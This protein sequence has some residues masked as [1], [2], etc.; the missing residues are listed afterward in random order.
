MNFQSLGLKEEYLKEM[1]NYLK[2]TEFHHGQEICKRGD[3]IN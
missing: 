1:T 2:L 3:K